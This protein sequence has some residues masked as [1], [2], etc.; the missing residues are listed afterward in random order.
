VLRLPVAPPYDA[1]TYPVAD[2]Y[3]ADSPDPAA[4]RLRIGLERPASAGLDLIACCDGVLSTVP[5]DELPPDW[6]GLAA[7]PDGSQPAVT[8]LYLRPLSV[9]THGGW[10]SDL[11]PAGLGSTVSWFVYDNVDAAALSSAVTG[12]V[13][14]YSGFDG[15]TLHGRK[16]TAAQ[17][18]EAFAEG[19]VGIWVNAGTV[20]GRAAATATGDRVRVEFGVQTDRGYVDPVA[21]LRTMAGQLD[22]DTADLVAFDLLVGSPWPVLG[23]PDSGAL[24]AAAATQ[25]YP[26]PVLAE[27]RQRLG[28][29][30]NADF[31][32]L[33]GDRQ[34]ALYWAQ[35][36]RR[37]GFDLTGTAFTFSTDDMAN[38][39]QLEAVTEFFLTWGQPAGPPVD[40]P[41][42]PPGT[43]DLQADSWNLVVVD[44]F[45]HGYL[46]G[47]ELPKPDYALAFYPKTP[48][49]CE[50]AL[51]PA[52]VPDPVDPTV[53]HPMAA[54]RYSAVLFVLHAGEVVGWYRWSSYT[55]HMWED[56]TR[57]ACNQ[58]SSIQ[59][60]LRYTFRSRTSPVPDEAGMVESSHHRNYNFALQD[61]DPVRNP[62]VHHTPPDWVPGRYYFRQG[63]PSDDGS[64]PGDSRKGKDVVLIHNGYA[65]H[66]KN[67][68][69]YTTGS[70]GCLVSPEFYRMRA[71]VV[72]LY[73][74]EY[75]AGHGGA[76]DPDLTPLLNRNLGESEALHAGK[77]TVGGVPY[78]NEQWD[79]KIT[80]VMYLVRPDEPTQK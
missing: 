30:G 5:P 60:N 12:A 73:E 18:Q 9:A 44:P 39:F 36:R 35:L 13:D 80:G 8:R 15:I 75:R 1:A 47:P 76:D 16:L 69:Q 43:V 48:I 10:S 6:Y 62:P 58:A 31:W 56:S 22:A 49:W 34:K 57:A 32:R 52:P 77:P 63:Q 28:L 33:L 68:G 53:T 65:I 66:N 45:D 17:R 11:Y 74:S 78:L 26:L 61:T 29:D 19:Q 38:P 40:L 2:P 64:H 50:T 41:A 20:L 27:A 42:L 72:A 3:A 23:A 71:R 46:G 54:D 51:A 24:M 79:N 67:S 37:A 4:W 14:S 59:G 7:L 55:S 70:G 25:L 21:L